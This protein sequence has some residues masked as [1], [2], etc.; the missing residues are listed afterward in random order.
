MAACSTF[1]CVSPWP[2]GQFH[3]VHAPSVYLSTFPHQALSARLSRR[4]SLAEGVGA[5]AK[6]DTLSLTSPKM[7]AG[8]CVTVLGARR[9]RARQAA[10][11]AAPVMAP[12]LMIK[13][14]PCQNLI[15]KSRPAHWVIRTSDLAVSLDFFSKVFGMKVLRHE[16]YERP[17]A[18]TCNG[19]F[20]TPWSKTMVGYGPE[21]EGY[22][23]ELTYN[24]GISGYEPGNG[25]AHIGVGVESID[26]A[27]TSAANMGYRV[28][29]GMI[30]GPDG[31]S[32]R[33]M[34]QPPE[35]EERFQYVALRTA[36]L[37]K[38][39]E[40]YEGALGMKD[41]SADFEHAAIAGI[42]AERTRVMGYSSAQVPLLLFEDETVQGISVQQWEGRNAVAVPGF[43]LRAI[44]QRVFEG[45]CGG[46][47][48]HPIREFNEL[49]ALRRMRGLPPMPCD[50][51]PE[52]ALRA[53]REDPSSAPPMG[54]LAVAIITDA[55]G[56]EICLVSS[57]TYDEAVARAYLLGGKIDW[58]WRK[59][60][61]AGRR[62][63][64]PPHML[65]C[66]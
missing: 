14:D 4:K 8:F 40:F 33:A 15:M 51:P 29:G 46:A 37:S 31:Y 6:L 58:T 16:E 7:L 26:A 3:L 59:E 13:A 57:E 30:T 9:R 54:T 23:L 50:P 35:R 12:P 55:D 48:L 28:E 39:A 60:A 10:R 63:A 24:Y 61:I 44:Y 34:L 43:A 22:C 20:R 49:P 47:I 41:L 62:T 27:V 32:F 1:A 65:A 17:C 21:D 2:L 25:L 52:V 19:T 53:L 56:Y 38:A 11:R 45:K 36:E 64:T 5:E 18:I 42:S 66:V